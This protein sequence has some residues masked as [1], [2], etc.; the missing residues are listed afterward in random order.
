MHF[1]YVFV[2]SLLLNSSWPVL[3]NLFVSAISTFLSSTLFLLQFCSFVSLH[4]ILLF[5]LH[6]SPFMANTQGETTRSNTQGETSRSNTQ[7]ETTRSGE[8]R[9][10]FR[11][12]KIFPNHQVDCI[13]REPDGS[14]KLYFWHNRGSV[15]I[16]IRVR[17]DLLVWHSF[18]PIWDDE[19]SEPEDSMSDG[20]GGYCEVAWHNINT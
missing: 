19:F 3:W 7:G 1:F 4:H 2:S 6:S 11:Y 12:L 18:H 13:F 8:R 10:Q 15:S 17:K 14:S 20:S 5:N 16:Y 9:P